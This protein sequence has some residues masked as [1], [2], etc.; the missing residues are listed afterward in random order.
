[1]KRRVPYFPAF[2]RCASPRA[3]M[4]RE[5]YNLQNLLSQEIASFHQIQAS[6]TSRILVN[7]YKYPLLLLFLIFDFITSIIQRQQ[8]S[9]R[10]AVESN[11]ASIVE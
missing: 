5:D 4:Q 10:C 6:H 11:L 2:L 3:A 9:Q 1:M 8:S 7:P